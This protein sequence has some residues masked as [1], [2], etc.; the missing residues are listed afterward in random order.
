VRIGGP[1]HSDPQINQLA[2][3]KVFCKY[4]RENFIL[5][6]QYYKIFIST[7]NEK[8]LKEAIDEFG[9]DKIVYYNGPII[10]MDR[11]SKFSEKEC[12]EK[13]NRS[14]LDFH[15]TQHCDKIM[16][17]EIGYGRLGAFNRLDPN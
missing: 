6:E 7:D 8:V 12:Q 9:K 15:S 10:H 2:E 14:Y 5:G 1:K 13:M 4:I 17:S 11:E 16:I 3:A